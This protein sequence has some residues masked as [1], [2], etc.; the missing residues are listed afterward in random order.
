MN[1]LKS[2]PGERKKGEK[3]RERL[4]KC[5]WTSILWFI[6]IKLQ[7]SM[8]SSVGWKEGEIGSVF[9]RRKSWFDS[10]TTVVVWLCC[11]A[12]VMATF[13]KGTFLHFKS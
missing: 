13:G 12:V 7:Q 5:L 6:E 11:D 2:W 4:R 3:E 9:N 1:G 10:S 8:I